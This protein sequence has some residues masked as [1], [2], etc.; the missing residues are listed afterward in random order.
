MNTN[1][2][3][4]IDFIAKTAFM[5]DE[6]EDLEQFALEFIKETYPEFYDVEINSVKD[7]Q[8]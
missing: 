4:E 2:S 7:T 3:L 6:K 8:E 1:T 5:T